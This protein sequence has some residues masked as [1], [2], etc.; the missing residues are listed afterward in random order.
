MGVVLV[1]VMTWL[2]SLLLSSCDDGHCGHCHDINVVVTATISCHIFA[3]PL[4]GE[5]E[6]A[7]RWRDKKQEHVTFKWNVQLDL[8]GEAATKSFSPLMA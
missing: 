5:K 8:S 7:G 2:L 1:D 6:C 3:W 4:S